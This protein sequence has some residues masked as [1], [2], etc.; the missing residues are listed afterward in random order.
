MLRQAPFGFVL[1]F[2]RFLS[3]GYAGAGTLTYRTSG[4]TG[5][6][7]ATVT[8]RTIAAIP[9]SHG[10][11]IRMRQRSAARPAD[12]CSRLFREEQMIENPTTL[13]SIFGLFSSEYGLSHHQISCYVLH[14]WLRFLLF[15]LSDPSRRF[16]EEQP[17]RV[18][19]WRVHQDNPKIRRMETSL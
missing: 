1:H 8:R 13:G 6:I 7:V 15:P 12:C 2:F 10:N 14:D 16:C 17:V 5:T 18:F 19:V 4:I 3:A 9:R 11:H